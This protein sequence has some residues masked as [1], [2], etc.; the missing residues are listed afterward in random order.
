MVVVDSIVRPGAKRARTPVTSAVASAFRRNAR[1]GAGA[2]PDA[3]RRAARGAS[4]CAC[5][6]S[7]AAP[8]PAT[9]RRRGSSGDRRAARWRCARRASGVRPRREQQDRLHAFGACC[10]RTGAPTT[11]ESTH[12]GLLVQRALDVLRKDVQPF[13]RHD[14]FLLAPA[15]EQPPVGVELAD[16]AGV[17][18]A[19]LRTPR[20]SPPARCSSRSSRSRRGRGSRRR[21]RS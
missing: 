10:R 1:R 15:D 5:L 8:C 3:A 6:P 13:R 18:P 19:V 2:L 9:R 21:R 14:H 11:A 20:A 7:A 17:E 12:A 16:V 4:A